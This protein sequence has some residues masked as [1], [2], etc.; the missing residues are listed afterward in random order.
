MSQVSMR[1]KIKNTARWGRK[2]ELIDLCAQHQCFAQ[3]SSLSYCIHPCYHMLSPT[4]SQQWF[5]Q[6]PYCSSLQGTT[7]MLKWANRE[8]SHVHLKKNQFLQLFMQQEQCPENERCISGQ[9]FSNN[10][11]AMKHPTCYILFT[12]GECFTGAPV[13]M[14]LCV[15][16]G[17]Q[18]F[19][20]A[21]VRH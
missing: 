19:P 21:F 18:E 17:L 9:M 7:K 5:W 2:W 8:F 12:F 4:Y 6:A 10:S 20:M 13:R 3:V 1:Q 14:C 11:P 15:R 16:L